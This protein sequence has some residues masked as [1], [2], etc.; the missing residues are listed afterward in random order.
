MTPLLLL[1]LVKSGAVVAGA[2]IVLRR[3]SFRE[4]PALISWMLCEVAAQSATFGTASLPA[5]F[6][7]VRNLVC[8]A[9]I[10]EVIRL[11]RLEVKPALQVRFFLCVL[12][13]AKILSSL[14]W[15]TMTQSWYLFRSWFLWAAAG[16]ML[17]I[18]LER[19]IHPVLERRAVQIYR[20]GATAWVL[21]LAVAGSFVTGGAG[22]K[23]FPHTMHTWMVMHAGTSLA[24]SAVVVIMSATMAASAPARKRAAKTPKGLTRTGHLEMEHAA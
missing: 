23:L 12:A 20:A 16:T 19:W 18:C 9:A 21:V 6:I 7:L 8:I 2:W 11:S 10:C 5:T 14:P 17:A 1:Q 3:F 4:F 24:V 22:Y 13:G 15:L